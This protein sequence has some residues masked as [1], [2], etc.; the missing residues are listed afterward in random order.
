[1]TIDRRALRW[2]V[3][4]SSLFF[5][6]AGEHGTVAPSTGELACAPEQL[7]SAWSS[8][9]GLGTFYGSAG[10]LT[11]NAAG[12]H[13]LVQD[14][15]RSISV[16][17]SDGAE[18]DGTQPTVQLT[19][20]AGVRFAE[21]AMTTNAQGQSDYAGATQLFVV[22]DTTPLASIPWIVPRDAAGYT[23]VVAHVG[24]TSDRAVLVE[25]AMV[26]G[27]TARGVWLRSIDVAS[28]SEQRV[29]LASALE[30]AGIAF[31]A[32][33]ELLVDEA[34]GVA[35]VTN[36]PQESA[37]QITRVDPASGTVTSTTLVQGAP[38]PLVG[39]A[40]VGEPGTQL[41]AAALDG[42]GAT[43]RVTTRDG[44]LHTLD[45]TTLD[46]IGPPEPVGVVVANPDTYLP[47]LRSPVAATPHGTVVASI[48]T[49]GH[50]AVEDSVTGA[51]ATLVSG[52]TAHDVDGQPTL[53]HVIHLRFLPDGLLVVSD[54]GIERFRCGS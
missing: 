48:T 40:A 16:R 14:L 20:V 2:G 10:A 21:Q 23:Q 34:R 4:A 18:S 8:A 33:F 1:M 51:R 45:A 3:L 27:G 44:V 28:T 25:R 47:S 5:G 22:G 36:G 7:R 32:P 35:F 52:A 12:T 29:D 30:P 11:L 6:C 17:L 38:A 19:D 26:F 54:A 15:F 43:L 41:L 31:D 39:V 9:D 13:V 24:Q 49:D 53:P 37:P 46:E 42:D 50:V